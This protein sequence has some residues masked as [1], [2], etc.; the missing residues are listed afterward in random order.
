M[1][2]HEMMGNVTS[3]VSAERP[4][5]ADARRNYDRLVIAAREELAERGKD[6]GIEDIAKRAG[7]GIG[8]L[9]RHF[10][11]RI[12]L[13]EAVYSTDIDTLVAA[14]DDAESLPDAFAGL[15][16][17][18]RAFV[19]YA[20][21]KRVVLNELHEA[22]ERNP[23]L[24]VALRERLVASADKVLTRAKAAGAVSPD[25]TADDLLQLV[26]GMC[27]SATAAAGQPDR[28]LTFIIAGIRAS[29]PTP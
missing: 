25:L 28:L 19:R 14:A 10:P 18:L 27:M 29:A 11:R 1:T 17:W 12:D 2:R 4:M 6:A 23:G 3:A 5:R 15:E 7:V 9:Y 26:G 8:T 24:R 22:F 20:E 16:T 13:I 21:S